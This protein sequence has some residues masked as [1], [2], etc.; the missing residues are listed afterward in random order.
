MTV[1][2][3]VVAL[4]IIVVVRY[5]SQSV[6][7]WHFAFSRRVHT[8]DFASACCFCLLSWYLVSVLAFIPKSTQLL[9]FYAFHRQSYHGTKGKTRSKET[10][11]AN[12]IH[13]WSA[14]KTG[15]SFRQATVFGR[16]W[17]R[18]PR[19]RVKLVR[20]PSQDLVS[21]QEN[22]VAKGAF[23]CWTRRSNTAWKREF[24]GRKIW[25][26]SVLNSNIARVCD[27]PEYLELWRASISI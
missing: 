12:H 14:E 2:I 7:R 4:R 17:K 19:A 16:H 9:I 15:V 10:S 23:V 25:L 20:D 21:E 11:Q 18:T 6:R 24:A 13:L 1:F 5:F 27:C 3:T 8:R 26:N 22:K